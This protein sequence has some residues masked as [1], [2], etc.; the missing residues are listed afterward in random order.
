MDRP[1]KASLSLINGYVSYISAPAPS[2]AFL[3]P[4]SLSDSLFFAMCIEKSYNLSIQ[5]TMQPISKLYH[6]GGTVKNRTLLATIALVCIYWGFP[7]VAADVKPSKVKLIPP[8]Q[9]LYLSLPTKY[10][11]PENIQQL[12]IKYVQSN[13]ELEVAYAR[14]YT[15]KKQLAMWLTTNYQR[16]VE[17]IKQKEIDKL[18]YLL[19]ECQYH[20]VWECKWKIDFWR[21][22]AL[23]FAR[24]GD[25]GTGV[26]ASCDRIYRG[27][28]DVLIQSEKVDNID[29]DIAPIKKDLATIE[30]WANGSAGKKKAVNK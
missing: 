11:I 17:D 21:D 8:I 4:R 3:C 12:L 19:A 26:T 13:Q 24:E 16:V 20:M 6:Q 18:N 1:G 28:S 5:T 10:P 2:G 14:Y 9:G 25:G 7:M 23:Y 22:K 15:D 29:A 27:I 30:D